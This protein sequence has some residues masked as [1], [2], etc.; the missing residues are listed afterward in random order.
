RH[1]SS[2]T[3]YRCQ[4]VSRGVGEAVEPPSILITSGNRRS[5][6]RPPHPPRRITPAFPF[7]FS[8]SQMVDDCI[9]MV[10]DFR[11]LESRADP[12]IFASKNRSPVFQRCRRISLHFKEIR[13]YNY[14]I[15]MELPTDSR[16][17]A[18]TRYRCFELS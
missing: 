18:G 17:G 9:E 7:A 15:F 12:V 2:P 16:T 1:A 5:S 3:G 4:G 10:S 11:A 6:L 13:C 14:S 8:L